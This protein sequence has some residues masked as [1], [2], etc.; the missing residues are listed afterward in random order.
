MHWIRILVMYIHSTQIQFIINGSTT[1]M[2]K[3]FNLS[4]SV[5]HT[6]KLVL[7]VNLKHSYATSYS[8]VHTQ[9]FIHYR[10][11]YHD[12][13]QCLIRISVYLLYLFCGFIYE[14]YTLGLSLDLIVDLFWNIFRELKWIT[15]SSS[16]TGQSNVRFFE[17]LA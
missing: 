17:T 9:V 10:K 5:M 7:Y 13:W 1:I 8:V 4:H 14:V 15:K 16:I 3:M 12:W 2:L 6:F 11:I